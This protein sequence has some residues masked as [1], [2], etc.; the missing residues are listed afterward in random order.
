MSNRLKGVKSLIVV[1]TLAALVAGCSNSGGNVD[2]ATN[3]ENETSFTY[4]GAGP[5]TDKPVTLSILGTNA[6]S[7]NV[8]LAKADIVNEIVKRAG[9]EVNWE[10]IPPQNYADAVSP[11]LA[12]GID[13][14]DIV[15]MPDQDQLMKYIKSGLVIPI[16]ELYEKYAVN[17]KS[18]YEK[19][20][21]IKASLTTP[22]GKMYYVPQQVLTKNYMP[23]FMVNMRWLDALGLKE[24]TTLDEFTEMLRKFKN[25]DPNQN[26][27]QDEVPFT[28]DPKFIPM[29]FG[30]VFGM[31]LSNQFYTDDSNKVHFGYYEPVYKD[32]L[33]YLNGLYK[34]G[35]LSMDFASTTGDQVTAR[36]SQNTAGATFNFSWYTSMVYSPL[37]ADYDPSTP[38]IKGI[39]PLK[40]P[41][42]DQFYVGRTP[43]SGIFGISKNS[44]NP[45]AAFKFL[46][47]AVSDEAKD[48]Y[49]WGLEG[50]TY[51][52]VD[53]K[54]QF[55]EQGKNNDFIQKLGI[56]PVNLPNM[57]STD[58]T[59]VLVAPWHA[60]MDK[61]IEPF[62]KAPFPFVYALPEEASIEN[63]YMADITTYVDEMNLKFI[64]GKENLD[65]FDA[66][67]SSLK[68]MGIEE[69]LEGKQAQY[70][71]YIAAVK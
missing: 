52:V 71:R 11:R 20:P 50:I 33:T 53:G 26:G 5:I 56:G 34:E 65:K 23:L 3:A 41:G 51:E 38:I 55:T 30:P 9:I 47:M 43:V 35:L 42:G 46:D 68:G 14:P 61:K 54:K 63:Q 57:Q 24:P 4:T 58:S 19:S 25:D 16:N 59:D 1:G 31:D 29:A 21:D 39:L 13:L 8:D 2:K 64:T 28:S 66:Y 15:Y 18:I 48:N 17:L 32:Y 22:D 67:L 60:E 70:D 49:T 12:A 45:D 69:V 40:G 62:I 37:F 6:W 36:F 44:K 27:E 10:L 7:T